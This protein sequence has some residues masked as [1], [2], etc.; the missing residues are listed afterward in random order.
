MKMNCITAF[1]IVFATIVSVQCIPLSDEPIV[2]NK[3]SEAQS[4]IDTIALEG[5]P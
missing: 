2:E 3:P 1:G 4:V 5:K